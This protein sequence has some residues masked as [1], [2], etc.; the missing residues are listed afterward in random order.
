MGQTGGISGDGA[1]WSVCARWVDGPVSPLFDYDSIT[2]LYYDGVIERYL[3]ETGPLDLLIPVSYVD[4][5]YLAHLLALLGKQ[6]DDT[7][8]C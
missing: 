7:R 6:V 2:L 3:M 4:Y 8:R 5:S 1:S